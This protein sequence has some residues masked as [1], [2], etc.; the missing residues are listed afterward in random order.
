MLES[1]IRKD[2]MDHCIKNNLISRRQFGFLK[3]RST[4]L[5]LLTFIDRVANLLSEG[6]SV[7]T[8]YLDYS[9]AFDTVPHHRLLLK[10]ESYG[11]TGNI[12]E[13]IKD[14]L[15]GRKQCVRVN[16][17]CSS[18]REVI[19]GVPQGS[20]LGPLLF[21]I[22]I[23]DIVDVVKN[24]DMF[25]FAD[26][27]KVA[28]H[29]KSQLDQRELHDDLA[30]LERWSRDWLLSF[31]PDK[32]HVLSFGNFE[33]IPCWAADYRI[34]GKSLEHVFEERDLGVIVDCELTF[35]EHIETQVKKANSTLGLIRRSFTFLDMHT[36]VTL[37][38]VFVRPHL[39]YAQAVWSPSR[40]GLISKIEKVQERALDLVPEIK[41]LPYDQQLVESGLPSLAY[42]RHR[43]DMIETYKHF[44]HSDSYDTTVLSD[45]FQLNPRLSRQHKH[46]LRR[47]HERTPLLGRLFYQRIAGSWNDLE[48]DTVIAPN[49]DEFKNRLDINLLNQNFI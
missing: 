29:I 45:S 39:E 18:D 12:L 32:F 22:Y 10:L 43:G 31:H 9:K 4:T 14:F 1:I 21:V 34:K 41:S 19:S 25:L 37:F 27:S 15:C 36:L 20:V 33:D 30:A 8:V 47:R 11:I 40:K 44:S 42:R 5:Q 38:K 7:D 48:E 17:E 28:K 3:G 6:G 46:Q 26:D 13:W 2:L 35:E 23:N 16:G 49:I 24:S